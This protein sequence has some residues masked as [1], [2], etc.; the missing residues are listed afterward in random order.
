MNK[1][2]AFMI[3]FLLLVSILS[4]SFVLADRRAGTDNYGWSQSSNTFTKIPTRKLC[5]AVRY[6]CKD[7]YDVWSTGCQGQSVADGYKV[8]NDGSDKN[9]DG[10]FDGVKL[11]SNFCGTQQLDIWC[12]NDNYGRPYTGFQSWEHK[13]DDP[14]PQPVCGDGKK[15]GSEQCDWG[16]SNSNSCNAPY[17]GSCTTCTTSCKLKTVE[18]GY[19]GD[20]TIQSS[21]EECE[22]D[23]QC[24]DGNPYT[25]DSCNSCSCEYTQICQDECSIEDKECHGNDLWECGNYD[26][27]PCLEWRF[28]QDC[29]FT[30]EDEYYQCEDEDSVQYIETTTGFCKDNFGH[31]DYCDD[32]SITEEHVTDCGIT[33]C[34]SDE[35]CQNNDVYSQET[36]VEKGCYEPTGLCFSNTII[37]N[38]VL[39][40][41]CSDSQTDEYCDGENIVYGWQDETCVEM[42]G[43]AFCDSESG[44]DLVEECGPDVCVSHTEL[45]PFEFEYVEDLNSCEENGQPYCA[46]PETAFDMCYDEDI[47]L[48]P[49]C[50]GS[51]HDWQSFDCNQYDG[52]YEFEI[53]QCF[54]CPDSYGNCYEKTCSVTGLKYIDYQCGSGVC[55][56]VEKEMVDADRDHKDDEYCDDCIDVDRD[57]VCDDVDNCPGIKNSNQIDNDKDGYGNACDVDRDGDGYPE[58]VDCNDWDLKVHPGAKEIPNNGRDEDCNSA[59]PDFIPNTPRE[60]LYVDIQMQDE[61]TLRAG[62]EFITVVS[63]ANRGLETIGDLRLSVSLPGFQERQAKLIRKLK[64]GDASARI[65]TFRL[66]EDLKTKY[67]YLRVS[68]SNDKYKRIIYREVKLPQ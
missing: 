38:P 25:E 66:P 52:C 55:F 41:E 53:D 54:Y 56:E 11:L 5:F 60:I 61:A 29:S 21:Y 35:F 47:L 34:T 51:D 46:L 3:M 68:V 27:D 10:Y 18:G 8:W 12:P 31:N 2:S 14:K 40:D 58:G 67:E 45:D 59:T 36:C 28:N 4:T 16:S 64:S 26:S 17:E 32:T 9:G 20:G 19:C 39:E 13:C 24:N 15:E 48:Q 65:F 37:E 7:R 50:V 22:F 30:T 44:T 33:E 42:N 57:G 1:K 63:V 49:Y 43:D 6:V 62:E 23:S